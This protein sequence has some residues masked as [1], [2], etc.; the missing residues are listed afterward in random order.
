MQNTTV[1]SRQESHWRSRLLCCIALPFLAVGLFACSMSRGAA[2]SPPSPTVT[3]PSRKPTPRSAPTPTPTVTILSA[4]QTTL[5]MAHRYV[6]LIMGMRYRDAYDLLSSQEQNEVP[7]SVYI[8][9]DNDVLAPGC[10][11]VDEYIISQVN[12]L[13]WDVGVILIQLSCSTSVS[14]AC[15]DWH[16]RFYLL[17][18]LPE[19]VSIGLYPTGSGPACARPYARR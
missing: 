4:K 18:Q 15:Y 6:G 10:W 12:A 2:H 5:N 14:L 16:L 3:L 9:N 19:I 1:S 11:K 17:Y 8:T 13:T 7:Y